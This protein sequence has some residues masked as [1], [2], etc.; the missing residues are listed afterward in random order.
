MIVTELI[1]EAVVLRSE[2][3]IKDIPI[4]RFGTVDE[5]AKILVFLSSDACSYVNG[6]HIDITGAKLCVQNPQFA[7]NTKK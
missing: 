4:R 6:V 5:V 2:Q 3:L 7:W 1:K